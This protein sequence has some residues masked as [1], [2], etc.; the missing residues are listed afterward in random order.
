MSLAELAASVVGR[1]RAAIASAVSLVENRRKD[2]QPRIVELLSRLRDLAPHASRTFGITGPPGV[3]KS[4]LVSAL[5]NELRS[6]GR[7]VGVLAVDPSSIRSGGAL[8]G[9]RARIVCDP[10]DPG[11]FVRSM[12]SGGELGGLARAAKAAVFVL[13]RA[14]DVVIVETIGVGQTET[15]VEHIVD[16][17]CFVAQP[18]SG[19][20]LQFLKAGI[21]EIPDVF[22]VNKM[23]LGSLA[24]RA[25]ADLRAA[26]TVAAKASGSAVPPSIVPTS[27]ATGSGIAE[28]V[29]AADRHFESLVT[30]GK[31]HARRLAGDGAWTLRFFERRHGEAAIEELGGRSTV[32]EHIRRELA[33]GELPFTVASSLGKDYLRRLVKRQLTA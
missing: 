8:L 9:D 20:V 13:A 23:D 18:A 21:L 11:I 25:K 31:L 2:A 1:E 14:F 30:G 7:T 3:G 27:A 4:T 17:V 12:A 24:R 33:R 32:Y 19:D 16:T 29:Q 28:L 22:V 5:A 6:Q 15:E 10:E 26:L